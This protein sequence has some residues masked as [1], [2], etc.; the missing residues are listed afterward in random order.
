MREKRFTKNWLICGGVILLLLSGCLQKPKPSPANLRITVIDQ[1]TGEGIPGTTVTVGERQSV[2]DQS[3]Q[4]DVEK[5]EPGA[6]ILC[7]ERPWY[8]SA[9]LN[10]N[11]S[12]RPTTVRMPLTGI[13]LAGTILYSCNIQGGHDIFALQLENR[14]VT[15]ITD[16]PGDE[17]QAVRR[18]PTQIVFVSDI[19]PANKKDLYIYDVITKRAEAVCSSPAN[20]DHPSIDQSGKSMVFHSMRSGRGMVYWKRLDDTTPPTLLA[21]G[22]EP[23]ISPNGEQVAYINNKK[24]W[25]FDITQTV[26]GNNPRIVATPNDPGNPCWSPDGKYVAFDAKPDTGADRLIFVGTADRNAKVVQATVRFGLSAAN[27][28]HPCWSQV[29]DQLLLLFNATNPRVNRKEIFCVE[30]KKQFDQLLSD[31]DWIMVS[32]QTGSKDDPH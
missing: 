17:E 15:R 18:T 22:H 32:G 11:F 16:F 20:D 30:L 14:S 31:N 12:G 5:M 23:E 1:A 13:P 6:Y 29:G 19:I 9:K 25:L 3:G 26:S 24:L 8:Q 10:V 21:E 4:I 2:T 27:H 7:F 28:Q